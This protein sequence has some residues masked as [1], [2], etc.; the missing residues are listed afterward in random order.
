[1][2]TVETVFKLRRKFYFG[3]SSMNQTT[4]ESSVFVFETTQL[5]PQ[6]IEPDQTQHNSGKSE[7]VYC[8]P[9]QKSIA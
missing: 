5:S 3:D 4:L 8:A 2:L 6:N 9:Y 7:C 1:M